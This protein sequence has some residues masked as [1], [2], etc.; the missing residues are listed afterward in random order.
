MFFGHKTRRERMSSRR[1]WPGRRDIA[2]LTIKKLITLGLVMAISAGFTS[3]SI[4]GDSKPKILVIGHWVAPATTLDPAT[5]A[6]SSTFMGVAYET[7]TRYNPEK[8]DVDPMLATDW[9]TPDK[10][11]TWTFKIR[12]GVKFHDGTDLD[13]AAVKFSIERTKAT[14]V[15]GWVWWAVKSIEVVD[16]LTVKFTCA[17]PQPLQLMLSSAFGS[18]IMSPTAVQKH[19]AEWM[20]THEAGTGAY[21][22]KDYAEG[23][24]ITLKRF[25][26]YWQ[27]WDGK[28]FDAAVI[29]VVPEEASRRQLIQAGKAGIVTKLSPEDRKALSSNDDVKVIMSDSWEDLNVKYNTEAEYTGNVHVRRALSYSLP[30]DNIIKAAWDGAA[31]R[32][33][34]LIPPSLWGAEQQDAVI[35][36]DPAIKYEYDLDKA[37]AALKKAGYAD[38]GFKLQAVVVS[39]DTAAEMACQL[40]K[41]SLNELGI[42]LKVKSIPRASFHSNVIMDQKDFHIQPG[43]WWPA[44]ASAYDSLYGQ[45]GTQDPAFLNNT[46]WSNED[47]D[48]LIEKGHTISATDLKAAGDLF[49]KAIAT[50]LKDA[51]MAN[52]AA[53]KSAPAYN[54]N[55]VGNWSG[56]NPAYAYQVDIY[57]VV[58]AE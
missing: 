30:Y 33:Y 45:L 4:A 15:L 56:F 24:L 13:A 12:E 53:V 48:A 28:H 5:E 37:R 6:A 41:E 34:G 38:G 35:N 43:T 46:F 16:S 7:L 42:E 57:N 44:Y 14:E 36:A 27:G 3:N 55:V 52:I 50:A 1:K 58:P 17:V 9:E 32:M 25:P 23:Q 2:F 21:M 54:T 39:G 26:D 51:P 11:I 10:G 31:I 40:W 18:Y 20:K 49:A 47:F 8:G 22:L 19:G 29:K